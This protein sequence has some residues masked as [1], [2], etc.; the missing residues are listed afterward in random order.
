MKDSGFTKL[1]G[2]VELDETWVGGTAKNKHRSARFVPKT[3]VIGA[4]S[5]KGNVVARVI[6]R[7]NHE[8]VE[9]F[10]HET[11]STKVDLVAS[12]ESTAYL[13]LPRL[14]YRMASVNHTRGEYVRGNVH[15]AN[16]DSFWSLLKRG[17]MGSFHNVSK[18]YLPLYVDEFS[19]RFNRR[20]DSDIFEQV[21]A[22]C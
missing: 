9:A 18:K 20:K 21:I 12:D 14:G 8:T 16:I 17:I 11:V 22:G 2:E 1:T 4:I 19:F 13:R 6:E 15:T 3:P 10:M 7:V 5:R